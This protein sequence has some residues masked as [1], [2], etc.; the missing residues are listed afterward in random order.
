MRRR[1]AAMEDACCP[2]SLVSPKE[3]PAW[4]AL[5]PGA[6]G[7]H[8]VQRAGATLLRNAMTDSA[9]MSFRS[10]ATI[11]AAFATFTYSA[12]GH[13]LRKLWAPASLNTSE[14]PPRTRSVGMLRTGVQ[15]FPVPLPIAPGAAPSRIPVPVILA[16]S[17][18]AYILGEAIEQPRSGAMWLVVGNGI[19]HLL[20]GVE[21][22]WFLIHE[23]LDATR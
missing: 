9:K 10:P 3:V 17:A 21:A 1:S 11:C 20:Q 18:E 12:C 22:L 23:G 4:S 5:S 6:S 19:S 13:C 16:I 2:H 8:F 14:R 15:P 7:Q